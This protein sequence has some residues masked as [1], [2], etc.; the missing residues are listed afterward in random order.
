MTGSFNEDNTY[1]FWITDDLVLY[2]LRKS[3]GSK[4]IFKYRIRFFSAIDAF[5]SSKE[6]GKR[7]HS[8]TSDQ[9][10]MFRELNI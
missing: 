8:F 9:E 7:N 10:H 4:I 1:L 5:M 2:D 6:S 3:I